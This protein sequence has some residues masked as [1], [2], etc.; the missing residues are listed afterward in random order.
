MPFLPTPLV[1]ITPSA[2]VTYNIPYQPGEISGAF[3]GNDLNSQPLTVRS[4]YLS[5]NDLSNTFAEPC[6]GSGNA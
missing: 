1:S 3:S 5:F 6:L 2:T 4:V